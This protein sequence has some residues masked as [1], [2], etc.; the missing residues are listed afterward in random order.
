MLVFHAERLVPTDINVLVFAMEHD[1]GYFYVHRSLYDQAVI[2]NDLYKDGVNSLC[3]LLGNDDTMRDDV[4]YFMDKAPEPIRILGPFLLMVKEPLE[5]FVDMVGAISVIS[6]QCDLR[7]MIK[8]PAEVRASLKYSLHIREEYQLSWD[9][10][11][12]SCV[13]YTP[14]V[15][16]SAYGQAPAVAPGQSVIS[17]E[18]A[19]EEDEWAAFA[20]ESGFSPEEL[21]EL[22]SY[23]PGSVSDADDA[24]ATETQEV[25]EIKEEPADEPPKKL[26]GLDIVRSFL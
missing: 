22:K 20:R 17:E 24:E 15:L 8:V 25:S 3:Q 6:T 4:E 16:V 14:P 21:E 1:S 10:F 5:A 7:N 18:E 13:P 23:V 2:L 9:R 26:S 19:E 11:I 12:A